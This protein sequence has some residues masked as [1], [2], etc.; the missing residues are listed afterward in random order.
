[1]EKMNTQ[2]VYEGLKAALIRDVES[3]DPTHGHIYGYVAGM[4]SALEESN[5][6]EIVG[7]KIKLVMS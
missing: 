4:L 1:M 3:K 2:Q 7:D 6:V 5:D